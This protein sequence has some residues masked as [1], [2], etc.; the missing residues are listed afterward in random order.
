MLKLAVGVHKSSFSPLRS[1]E[2]KFKLANEKLHYYATHN[3]LIA[4]QHDLKML[5]STLIF[6]FCIISEALS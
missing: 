3:S 4:K 1:R 6:V 2:R 5:L